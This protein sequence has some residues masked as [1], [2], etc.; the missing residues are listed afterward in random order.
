MKK[1][2]EDLK[3]D[4]KLLKLGELSLFKEDKNSFNEFRDALKKKHNIPDSTIK[5]ELKKLDKDSS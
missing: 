3:S 1:I 4:I 5:R 2:N